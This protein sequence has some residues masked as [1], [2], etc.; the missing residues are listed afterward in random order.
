MK[1]EVEIEDDSNDI[2]ENDADNIAEIKVYNRKKEEITKDVCVE[3]F[4]SRNGLLGLGT[5]LIRMAHK[6]TEGKHVH[7]EPV[8]D[9]QQ[10]QRMGVFLTPDSGKLI[11]CCNEGKCI[12]EYIKR[13]L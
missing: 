11:I 13:K 1:Y 12:D 5:E 7:L 10:V 4:L 9:E 2:F 6:F 3:M 8:D